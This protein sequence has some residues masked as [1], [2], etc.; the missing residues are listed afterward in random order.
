[1]TTLRCDTL[2]HNTTAKKIDPEV[3]R[4]QAGAVWPGEVELAAPDATYQL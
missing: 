3:C 4:A 1:M 2:S